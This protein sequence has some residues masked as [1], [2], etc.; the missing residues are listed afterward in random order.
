[1]FLIL[2]V[3]SEKRAGLTK[4]TNHLKGIDRFFDYGSGKQKQRLDELVVA[5]FRVPP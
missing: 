2:A 4:N 5:I 1:L 3:E